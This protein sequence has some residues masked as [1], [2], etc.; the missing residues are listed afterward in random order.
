MVLEFVLSLSHS[1]SLSYFPSA[2]DNIWRENKRERGREKK[3]KKTEN[4]TGATIRELVIDSETRG[5]PRGRV[6]V[7]FQR[8]VSQR[9]SASVICRMAKLLFRRAEPIT[10]TNDVL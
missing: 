2:W 5:I 4:K 7:L 6:S 9:S 1:S 3:C 10:V 8:R